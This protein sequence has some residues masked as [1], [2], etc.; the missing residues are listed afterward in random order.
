MVQTLENAGLAELVLAHI[1]KHFHTQPKVWQRTKDGELLPSQVLCFS[2]EPNPGNHTC[3]TF[4]LSTYV[5]QV[6]ENFRARIE[7]IM[8]A[9]GS[10][11]PEPVVALLTALGNHLLRTHRLS[12]LHTVLPGDGPVFDNPEFQHLYLTTP[13]YH[14]ESL[15]RLEATEPFTY[16]VFVFPI[17]SRERSYIEQHSPEAFERLVLAQGLNVLALD[18]RPEIV[19]PI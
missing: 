14:P 7:F 6:G 19:I 16:F 17:T 1:E 8:A 13:R 12:S 11:P 15:Y 3:V 10:S 18:Q 4:R 2:D 5:A 9:E